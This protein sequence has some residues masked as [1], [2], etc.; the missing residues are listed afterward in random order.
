MI[1][2][3]IDYLSNVVMFWWSEFHKDIKHKDI[4]LYSETR[5]FRFLYDTPAYKFTNFLPKIN[6]SYLSETKDLM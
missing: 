4:K 2:E 1:L 3:E 5:V 6:K